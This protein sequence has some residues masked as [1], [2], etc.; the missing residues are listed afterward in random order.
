MSPSIAHRDVY[1]GFEKA[2]VLVRSL[3]SRH[4]LGFG[5]HRNTVAKLLEE[6]GKAWLGIRYIAAE[7]RTTWSA[8]GIIEIVEYGFCKA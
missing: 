1:F 2:A 7:Q 8:L 6:G 4:H 3:P 5:D